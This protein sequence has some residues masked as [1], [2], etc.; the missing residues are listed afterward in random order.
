MNEQTIA[1]EAP[2]AAVV[3][4]AEPGCIRYGNDHPLLDADDELFIHEAAH[5]LTPDYEIVVERLSDASQWR[6]DVA[7]HD[8]GFD[9]D[10]TAA[11]A[12]DIAALVH[13]AKSMNA[14]GAARPVGASVTSGTGESAREL[15]FESQNPLSDP[16]RERVFAGESGL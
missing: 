6:V 2:P 3:S 8:T 14:R 5:V 10:T 1:G 12:A 13:V 11:L 15:V 16:E 4:C 7:V 9:L